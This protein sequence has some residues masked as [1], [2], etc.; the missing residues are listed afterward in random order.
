MPS[1]QLM[2]GFQQLQEQQEHISSYQL[3]KRY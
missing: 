2:C 3:H 1:F